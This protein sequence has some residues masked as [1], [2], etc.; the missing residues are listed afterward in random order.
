[1]ESAGELVTIDSQYENEIVRD[2]VRSSGTDIWL[3]MTDVASPGDWVEYNGATA[4]GDTVISGGAAVTG[5]YANIQSAGDVNGATEDHI[6]IQSD[7]RWNDAGGGSSF[8][9]VVQWDAN[10]VLSSFTFSLTDDAGGRFTVDSS[11]GE[12]TVADFFTD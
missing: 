3:G 9:Y 6:R 12:I 4:N 1:M 7:G 11:S 10:E 8:N 5:H 2:W